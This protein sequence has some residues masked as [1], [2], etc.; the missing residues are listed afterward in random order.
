M[1][2]HRWNGYLS[3]VVGTYARHYA[4]Q[5]G[6]QPDLSSATRGFSL[7]LEAEPRHVGDAGWRASI[8]GLFCR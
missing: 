8:A 4:L 5:P 6:Q 3:K 1:G 2:C 7:G